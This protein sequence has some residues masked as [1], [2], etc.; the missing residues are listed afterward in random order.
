MAT[1][2]NLSKYSNLL[3]V[4]CPILQIYGW[5][6]YTFAVIMS[7][8]FYVILIIKKGIH[9]YLPK[10]LII[11]FIYWIVISCFYIRSFHSI[12]L[13]ILILSKLLPCQLFFC[14]VENNTLIKYYKRFAFISIMFLFIQ[15]FIRINGVIG[16]LPL[17]RGIDSIYYLD[18]INYVTRYSSFFSE[19]AHFSQFLFPLLTISI[20]YKNYHHRYIWIALIILTL[21]LLQ[22]GNAIIGL[23]IILMMVFFKQMS[24]PKLKSKIINIVVV[25]CL[26][27]PVSYIYLSS[28]MGQDVLDRQD[29]L[30]S[31]TEAIS[32][33]F[34]RI[35]RG[36]YLF[37]EYSF[38]EQ[39]FG[40]PD[41]KIYLSKINKSP[42]AYTFI[43]ED[44]N[45]FFNGIQF[46][47][48]RTG[49][50]GLTI[51]L[52]LFASLWKNNNFCGRTLLLIIFIL[53]F[54]STSW[55]SYNMIVCLTLSYRIQQS[56]RTNNELNI[57][58]LSS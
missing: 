24:K 20:F 47:L 56:I 3:L 16:L 19:P 4:L 25:L 58:V 48:L 15:Q 37:K 40:I 6:Q 42:L 32:S 5:G 13:I 11:Y 1:T 10:A 17:A 49:Y 33:G 28:N 39:V 51:V 9:N 53:L 7:L 23:A 46:I 21:L 54:I 30:E 35:F 41:S 12:V 27:L 38:T 29:E 2:N 14:E 55:L 45:Y 36:Y 18:K 50:I 34:I 52:W 26:C 8:I 31:D 22:S 44:D 43:E 57:R